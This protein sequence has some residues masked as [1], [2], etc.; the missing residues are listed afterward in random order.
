[1]Q[2]NRKA[3]KARKGT[4]CIQDGGGAMPARA[5]RINSVLVL[6]RLGESWRLFAISAGLA[7]KYLD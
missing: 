4:L 5:I 1:M 3:R 6:F 2:F 7:V